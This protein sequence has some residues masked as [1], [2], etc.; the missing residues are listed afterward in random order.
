MRRALERFPSFGKT[1]PATFQ[2]LEKSTWPKG[3]TLF[4]E[5]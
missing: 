4:S 3:F 2:A 1:R 5:L